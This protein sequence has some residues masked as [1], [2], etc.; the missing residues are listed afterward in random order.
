MSKEKYNDKDIDIVD[1]QIAV[2]M[3]C[4]P[5]PES[6]VRALS[7]KVSPH[8]PLLNTPFLGERNLNKRVKCVESECTC[9]YLR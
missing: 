7:D 3:E 8:S 2:L 6:E 1:K 4:K 5:L 9:H